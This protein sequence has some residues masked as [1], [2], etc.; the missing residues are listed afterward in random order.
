M[1]AMEAKVDPEREAISCTSKQP[2]AA[3]SRLR[4]RGDAA[5]LRRCYKAKGRNTEQGRGK[6]R[7]RKAADAF[8]QWLS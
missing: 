6:E 1:L 5:L 7:K 3:H 2:A 4:S 8:F